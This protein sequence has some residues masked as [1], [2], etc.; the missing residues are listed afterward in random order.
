MPT[1]VY[2]GGSATDDN[3]TPRLGRDTSGKPGQAPGLST[4]ETIEQAASHGSKAHVIDLDLLAAPLRGYRDQVD[5]GG[6]EGHVSIAPSDE[7]GGI[8]LD[9]L[10]EWA[11]SRGVAPAHEF[12]EI[13]RRAVVRVEKRPK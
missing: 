13:V 6:T 3:L 7:S 5:Q 9:R 4:F 1:F 10:L 12:T 8:D 11:G 2:R